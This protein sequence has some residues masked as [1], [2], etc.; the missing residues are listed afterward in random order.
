MGMSKTNPFYYALALLALAPQTV[1]NTEA[2]GVDIKEPWS[3]G[4]VIKFFL[5][6]ATIPGATQ[7]HFYVYGK[8]R[9]DGTYVKLLDVSGASL[10]IA[11]AKLASG[12]AGSAAVLSASLDLSRV[13]STTYSALR[14]SLKN[15]NATAQVGGVVYE[16]ADTQNRPTGQVDEFANLQPA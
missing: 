14:V 6:L 7:L 15:D 3:L 12:G 13:D 1:N 5:L 9:S 4:R 11:Q 10:E 2:T 8:K 16:I